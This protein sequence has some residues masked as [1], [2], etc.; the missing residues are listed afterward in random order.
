MV[1]L[2]DTLHSAMS[3]VTRLCGKVEPS[4]DTLPD[5]VRSLSSLLHSEDPSVSR[6]IVLY[7]FRYFVEF[8]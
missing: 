8:I 3:V 5:S 1:F 2:Q 6:P 4:S 7:C